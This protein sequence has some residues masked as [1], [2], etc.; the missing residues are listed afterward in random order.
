M[1][2]DVGVARLLLVAIGLAFLAVGVWQ[3]VAHVPTNSWMRV[4][5]G[6]AAGIAVHD[7]VLAPLGVVS[8]WLVAR[9]CRS[10]RGPS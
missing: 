5:I 3:F 2:R 8:G 1:V 7:G 10:A 6:I 4:G 9:G